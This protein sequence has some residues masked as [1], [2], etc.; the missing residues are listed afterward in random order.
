M[1][2]WK[3][4]ISS[5]YS[6]GLAAILLVFSLTISTGAAW[7]RYRTEAS[8]GIRFDVKRPVSV[9]LGRMEY[10]DAS[11]EKKFVQTEAGSWE[12]NENGQLQ[13]GFA[14]ANGVSETEFEKQDQQVYFRVIGS[15]GLQNAG[16]AISLSMTFP[17]SDD[18]ET[19]EHIQATATRIVAGSPMYAT[20]GGGWMYCFTDEKGEELTWVLE[21]GKLSSIEMAL[22]LE[23]GTLTDTSL[24]QLQISSTHIK[25]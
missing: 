1:K 13:L 10:D 9:C 5:W 17:Q 14:V 4:N 23:N 2:R 8:D 25:E 18:P 24:L 22:T 6:L 19:F 15:L 21:G 3:L 20:F 11:G 7:A 12:R 16:K